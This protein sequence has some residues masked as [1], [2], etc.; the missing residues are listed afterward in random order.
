MDRPD[1]SHGARVR[2]ATPVDEELWSLKIVLAKICLSRSILYAYIAA[3]AFSDAEAPR[4]R[5][6]AWLASEAQ[7][8]IVGPPWILNVIW[9]RR[10]AAELHPGPHFVNATGS[11][12]FLPPSTLSDDI[13]W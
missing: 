2:E 12:R 13:D 6:I 5:R 3:A 10:M 9:I 1:A 7:A 8:W 4:S 11:T